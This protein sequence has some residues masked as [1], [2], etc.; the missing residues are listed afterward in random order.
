VLHMLQRQ[1][2]DPWRNNHN[3]RSRCACVWM[4]DAIIT[5]LFCNPS[6]PSFIYFYLL[7][8]MAILFLLLSFFWVMLLSMPF[9]FFGITIPSF[10]FFYFFEGYLETDHIAHGVFIWWMDGAY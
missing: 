4:D 7:L 5:P 2:V 10:Y 8:D 6:P 3:P 9:F 1:R